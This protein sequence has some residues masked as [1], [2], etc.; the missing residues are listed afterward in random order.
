M[1]EQFKETAA[2]IIGNKELEAT[3]IVLKS[4]R[5]TDNEDRNALGLVAQYTNLVTLCMAKGALEFY[6][7]APN[8]LLE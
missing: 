6:K 1:V 5:I 2:S 7:Y 4:L 3:D 8:T